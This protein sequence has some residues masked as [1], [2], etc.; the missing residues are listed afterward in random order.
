M[1]DGRYYKFWVYIL[2]SRTGTLYV[3]VTGFFDK[4]IHQHKYDTI[5]GFTK[6]Y[7]VHRLVYYESYQD[8]LV[9][10][11]REKQIKRWR[12]EKKIWLIEKLNPRWQD[13]AESW[14]REIKV[15][16]TV[17]GENSLSQHGSAHILGISRLR[18]YGPRRANILAALR[19]K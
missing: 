9:A 14:G 10:I 12:R 3:G 16:G 11:S 13:L 5:E 15:S 6:K 19:S 4:R 1:R 17:P 7:Q 8:V 18:A 2:S